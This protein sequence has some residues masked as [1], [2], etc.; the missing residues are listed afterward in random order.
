MSRLAG[1]NPGQLRQGRQT[2]FPGIR[3]YIGSRSFYLAPAGWSAVVCGDHPDSGRFSIR[4]HATLSCRVGLHRTFDGFIYRL[5]LSKTSKCLS[6]RE[7]YFFHNFSPPMLISLKALLVTL[8]SIF[9]SR[10]T[11]ELENLALRHQIGVLQRSAKK[12]PR[13]TPVDRLLWLWLSR[14]WNDWRSVLV[15]VQPDTVLAWHRKGFCSLLRERT[16]EQQN[17]LETN[18]R[19]GDRQ[20]GRPSAKPV[21]SR[22]P[23]HSRAYG[24]EVKVSLHPELLGI[25]IDEHTAMV[26]AFFVS[27]E[28]RVYFLGVIASLAALA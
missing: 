17:I 24:R 16:Q 9:R 14:L 3:S 5:C 27:S 18:E 6:V 12:R 28:T 19:F 1:E 10:G 11:L 8:S 20:G 26:G 7:L 15:I 25:G 22:P 23:Q 4:R 13:L 2:R 21:T